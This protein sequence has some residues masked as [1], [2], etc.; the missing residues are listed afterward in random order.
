MEE[1]IIISISMLISILSLCNF[2]IEY[3][4]ENYLAASAYIIVA[5]ASIVSCACV[6]WHITLQT[7][8]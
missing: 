6:M 3:K 5:I 1:V 2:F 8:V 7:I 4:K